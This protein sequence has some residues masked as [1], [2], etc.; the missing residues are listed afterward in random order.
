MGVAGGLTRDNMLALRDM[1]RM[2]YG[3]GL[4]EGKNGGKGFVGVIIGNDGAP[5]IVKMLTQSGERKAMEGTPERMKSFLD[6]NEHLR[7]FSDNA[8]DLLMKLAKNAGLECDIDKMIQESN[9]PLLTRE[10]VASAVTTILEK[11]AIADDVDAFTWDE[12]GRERASTNK[13]TSAE[14]LRADEEAIKSSGQECGRQFFKVVDATL[15]LDPLAAGTKVEM[16]GNIANGKFDRGWIDA[17]VQMEAFSGR[18]FSSVT[19][20]DGAVMNP[21]G[22]VDILSASNVDG[23]F[24]GD[25]HDKIFLDAFKHNLFKTLNSFGGDNYVPSDSEKLRL[26][27]RAFVKAATVRF[28]YDAIDNIVVKKC[29]NRFKG[30]GDIDMDRIHATLH[31]KLLGLGKENNDPIDEALSGN[32]AGVMDE[33]T[34]EKAKQILKLAYGDYCLTFDEEVGGV[35]DLGKDPRESR[36]I[37]GTDKTTSDWDTL[38]DYVD[39]SSDDSMIVGKRDEFASIKSGVVNLLNGVSSFVASFLTERSDE[40]GGKVLEEHELSNIFRF[41]SSND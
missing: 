35:E 37:S 16:L 23:T 12:V 7:T 14:D 2:A 4:G 38:L 34:P 33:S 3:S 10:I 8:K 40:L 39:P 32:L 5:R 27:K 41:S 30:S 13:H 9:K 29:K 36:P 24:Q 18:L 31:N 25:H 11:G 17:A 28:I 20:S 6:E 21:T 19:G 15:R 26:L 1:A 22:L